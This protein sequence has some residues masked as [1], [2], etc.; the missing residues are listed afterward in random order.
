MCLLAFPTE[1]IWCLWI[2]IDDSLSFIIIYP[3]VLLSCAKRKC[4]NQP[5]FGNLSP[6]AVIFISVELASTAPNF[7]DALIVAPSPTVKNIPEHP[8][9]LVCAEFALSM[10]IT[11][12]TFSSVDVAKGMNLVAH[13]CPDRCLNFEAAYSVGS[14]T[15][16]NV[17]LKKAAG[18]PFFFDWRK[19]NLSFLNDAPLPFSC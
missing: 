5:H 3:L 13:T 16:F 9:P 17:N 14:F 19:E 8:L 1:K 4:L 6:S 12:S 11:T 15:I 7:F 2:N 10:R 18:Q